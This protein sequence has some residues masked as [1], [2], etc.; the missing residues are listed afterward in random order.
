M[1]F[2]TV[3]LS[4][5]T[6]PSCEAAVAADARFCSNCG[7][8]LEG[9]NETDRAR[10]A[11]I[12]AAAPTPLIE[13]M[14]SVRLSGERKPVTALFADV[15]GSTTLAERMD[16]EDWTAMM[17]EAFDLMSR[18]VFR[19]EGTIAQLQGDAMLAFFG[20]P[21]A[22]EDDPS[23]AIM[24]GLDMMAA[25][26]E[27]ARQLQRSGG[28][29]FRIRAGI[30]TGPV[31]VGNV[32]TDLR[33]EYT[34][35]GDAVNVAA[36]M[37]SLAEPGTVIVTDHTLHLAPEAFDVDDLGA[38]DVKGK[39]ERVHAY[40]VVGRKAAPGPTRGLESVGLES[41][42]IGRA[43]LLGQLRA[44]LD[45]ASAGRGRAAFL[46]GEP[47]IGKSRLL[48]ELRRSAS[49]GAGSPAW[50]EAHCVSYGRNLP[51]HLIIDMVRSALDIPFGIPD[52][53]ARR[54][55]EAG[56]VTTVGAESSDVG[57]Y[58]AHLL[59]VP[60]ADTEAD[61]AGMEPEVLQSRYVAAV[62]RLLGGLA[63]SRPVVLVCEDLH[64][65]DPASVEVVRQ[66]LPMASQRAILTIGA[67]RE[68]RDS[69]G[70][71]LLREARDLFGEA[72]TE[73]RI[74]PL[75]ATESRQLVGNLLEIESLSDRV[76]NLILARAE[77]NPFFVEE[78][79]RMLIDRGVIVRRDDHWT[80][81]EDVESIEIPETLHGLLLARI[82]Q[83]PDAAKRSLR[84]AAVIGRQF[85]L[86]VLEQV[87]EAADPALVTRSAM[88]PTS[89]LPS[90]TM[91]AGR[92]SP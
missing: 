1:E 14:R 65:A 90:K 91:A 8:P 12:S 64:W 27:F 39:T 16:P 38:V 45:V 54:R 41:P 85:P 77:G 11:R 3:E 66:L 92:G 80:A 50:V 60:L 86:R 18:A 4:S 49:A 83:L 22:H 28:V 19:Y 79:V 70:W 17:N 42:M 35:L 36:R 61:L 71:G 23:R 29:D 48:A 52:D 63:A 30:N 37:Q 57:R 72:I 58:L 34:A 31:V 74:E 73:I 46:V 78:V 56:L 88:P 59:D 76:R 9:A 26:E 75:D 44:L 68:E 6:C 13:K 40:R 32:G 47:G 87:L 69:P 89:P 15:V 55:L 5:S 67:L 7:Q 84:V 2:M 33:Y 10:L 62:H 24:A 43:Q 82:D 25:T 51:Y 53:E 81:T 21:I 20:A